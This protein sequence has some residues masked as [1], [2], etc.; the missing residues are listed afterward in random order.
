MKRLL[1]ALL[2]LLC[3]SA[4]AARAQTESACGATVTTVGPQLFNA[5]LTSFA[6]TS[7]AQVAINGA[8]D[9]TTRNV[10]LLLYFNHNLYQQNASN[11]WYEYVS[12]GSY[13]GPLTDPRLTSSCGGGGGATRKGPGQAPLTGA[14]RVDPL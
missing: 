1:A 10:I 8:A 11:D 3:L 5:S 9:G 7:G 14:V 2:V 4:G 13:V 6:I 12:V